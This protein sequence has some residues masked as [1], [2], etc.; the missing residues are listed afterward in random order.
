MLSTLYISLFFSVWSPTYNMT[1]P[2]TVFKVSP[3]VAPLVTKYAIHGDATHH[4]VEGS[5]YAR[6]QKHA[7]QDERLRSVCMCDPASPEMADSGKV[8]SR[9]ERGA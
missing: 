2:P 7:C 4:C 9:V 1:Q 3:L 5:S 8:E 6:G